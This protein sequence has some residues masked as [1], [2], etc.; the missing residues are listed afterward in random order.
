[1]A[2]YLTAGILRTMSD[3][4]NGPYPVKSGPGVPYPD[5]AVKLALSVIVNGGS[6][7]QACRAVGE[8]F[9]RQPDPHTVHRWA[10]DSEEAFNAMRPA[11]LREYRVIA[12]DVY[13]AWGKRALEAATAKDKDGKYLVG[14]TQ[15]MV[16]FGIAKDAVKVIEDTVNPRAGNVMNV[17]WNLVT[18]K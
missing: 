5:D 10:Q 4:E 13:R 9:D 6:V 11:E 12:G 16:P 3:S 2:A 7:R 8:Q 1:M 15:V 18:S 17:Q 14:H